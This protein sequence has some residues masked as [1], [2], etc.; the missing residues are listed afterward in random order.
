MND[1][2]YVEASRKLAERAM[3]EGGSLPPDRASYAFRLTT[4]RAPQPE[5]LEVLLRA[6]ESQLNDYRADTESATKLIS[7]GES[8]RNES[9]D[10][11]ELAAWTMV[12][13]LILNLD[14]SVTKE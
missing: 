9:L 14:E 12:A 13:N 7:I 3:L 4:A 8:K 6:Y 1:E 11:S 5:E 2:Q 10:A